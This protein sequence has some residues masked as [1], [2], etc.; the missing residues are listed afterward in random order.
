VDAL[1]NGLLGCECVL[2][3]GVPHWR[4]TDGTAIPVIAGGA[5][6]DPKK[7]DDPAK[8]G[9]DD[10]A[11]GAA[12]DP[13]KGDDPAKGDAD[14]PTKG[15]AD[16]LDEAGLRTELA[17]ARKE[18]AKYR[19]EGKKNSERVTALESQMKSIAK[20]LGQDGQDPDPEQLQRQ[21]GEERARFRQERLRN[22]V[23]SAAGK[24]KADAQL[25][26]AL[27][28]ASGDLDNVDIAADDLDEQIAQRVKA[29]VEGNPR[30]K[31]DD[32]AA[33][34]GA[35]MGAGGAGQKALS[36]N[37]LIRRGAGRT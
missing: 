9:D 2:I 28:H 1:G 25:A 8:G 4:Y 21:L 32:G 17:R 36:M 18:A 20:A 3:G 22:L 35:D 34:G 15:D 16:G 14:D 19:T 26:W 6:D 31:L 12:D 23:T 27:L 13:K 10:P 11:K 5:D 29:A 33:R 30:L 37:D 7:G 24:E